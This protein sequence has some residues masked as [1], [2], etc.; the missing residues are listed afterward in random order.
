MTSF[1]HWYSSIN[2]LSVYNYYR[3]RNHPYERHCT[4]NREYCSI[5]SPKTL[6]PEMCVNLKTLNHR[7]LLFNDAL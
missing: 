7:S 3:F 4:C 6:I 5:E 1:I 2:I